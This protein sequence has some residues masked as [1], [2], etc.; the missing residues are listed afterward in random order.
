[1]VASLPIGVAVGVAHGCGDQRRLASDSDSGS[2]LRP[3]GVSLL[4]GS[5]IASP[6][7]QNRCSLGNL[8]WR[9]FAPADLLILPPVEFAEAI[10]FAEYVG[11]CL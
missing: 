4:S 2:L 7:S 8:L 1:M 6:S 10:E 9:T 5:A 3:V 11:S